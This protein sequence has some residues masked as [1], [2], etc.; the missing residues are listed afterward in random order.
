[1]ELC[2]DRYYSACGF[3]ELIAL[4]WPFDR[5]PH[6]DKNSESPLWVQLKNKLEDS[7]DSGLLEPNTRLPPEQ[8]FCEYLNVSKPVFR[9]ALSSLADQGKVANFPRKGMYVA[10]PSEYVDFTHTNLGAFCGLTEKGYREIA[11]IRLT[12]GSRS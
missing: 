1:M 9:V 7:I 3:S 10:A 8:I 11:E 4:I 2:I 6:P 5:Y 12:T